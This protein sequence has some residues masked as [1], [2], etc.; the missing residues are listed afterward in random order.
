M[1]MNIYRRISSGCIKSSQSRSN[2]KHQKGFISELK[3]CQTRKTVQNVFNL[4]YDVVRVC[5]FFY[6]KSELL[7]GSDQ[8]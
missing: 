4:N 5:L 8:I 3:S 1:N 2:E 7:L 6:N